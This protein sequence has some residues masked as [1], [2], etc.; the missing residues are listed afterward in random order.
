MLRK[1]LA[2]LPP[3]LDKTYERMLSAISE[4]DSEYAIR[5]LRWLTFSSRP[6]S[7]EEVAEV[8]AID[9]GHEP[10]FN[11]DEVLEDPLEALSICSSLVTVA[12]AKI[13][14]LEWWDDGLDMARQ[15]LVLAHY[16][17]KEYLTS[18]RNWQGPVSRYSLHNASSNEAIAMGCLGYLLQFQQWEPLAE[19]EI[20][21][22][23]LAQY[24]AASWIGHAQAAEDHT[25]SLSQLAINLLSKE[26]AAYLN[27]NRI[28]DTDRSWQIPRLQ[29]A[30]EQV[31]PPFYYAAC[32]GL[33]KIVKLLLDRGVDVNVQCGEY[34]NA[35]QAASKRG[36]EQVV[37]LLLDHGADINAWGA[38]Y[39]SA[40]Q[41]ASSSGHEQVVKLLL[42]HGADVNVWGGEYGGALQA[43]SARGSKEIVQL[44]LNKGAYVNAP[45]GFYGNALQVASA[46]GFKEIVQ[47][48][49][50]MNAEVNDNSESGRYGNALNAASGGGYVEVVQLLLNKGADIKAA[51]IDGMTP[52]YSASVVGHLEVVKLLLESGAD[53][54]ATKN[55]GFTPVNA[56][57]TK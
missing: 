27:W 13:P 3:N 33:P 46:R 38:I 55:N 1:S 18:E 21:N 34:G 29:K 14:S 44:L 40:L 53:P 42:N 28:H 37:K 54:N 30:L 45:G 51:S 24:A 15:V 43:A 25:E 19:E 10:A 12:T 4:E 6:L 56:A 57:S 8:V 16:S 26:N 48:L 22:F 36:H 9:V 39:G 7:I 2:T 50:N 49:L 41:A 31:R 11:R 52:V 32:S 47:L 20:K 17:V 5:I 23:K 35:V